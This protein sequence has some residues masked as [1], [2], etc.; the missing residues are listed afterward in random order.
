MAALDTDE[1][2]R[3][4]GVWKIFGERGAEVITALQQR[5]LTASEVYMEYDCHIGVADCSFDVRRGEIFCVMGLSGSG[6]STVVRHLNRLIEPTA[7]SIHVFGRDLLALKPKELRRLRAH[8]IGMVFQHMALLPHLTV[9]D[10]V[11]LPLAIRGEAQARSWQVA[12]DCLALVNLSGHEERYPAQLSGGMQQRV[13]LARA[14]AS[15]PSLLLMDEPFSA[16][17][18]LIRRQLQ[19]E[20]KDIAAQLQKTT[21]FI[22]HDLAEAVNIGDRIAMMKSGRIVQI[23][24]PDEII[25]HPADDYVREFVAG[26][27]K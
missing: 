4:E 10:N 5:Q 9:R 13:G 17:D 15:D 11:I 21:V 23:G 26:A 18:P 7:G 25:N 1:V 2:I 27:E 3:L 16:L 6:K 14:L 22:T 20:F 19:Q 8:E 12:R 24:T